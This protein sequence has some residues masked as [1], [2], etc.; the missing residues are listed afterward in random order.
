M[1]LCPDSIKS[2]VYGVALFVRIKRHQVPIKLINFCYLFLKCYMFLCHLACQ[3][4]LLRFHAHI[5]KTSIM[6]T[7]YETWLLNVYLK[8][9][10]DLSGER[11]LRT[12]EAIR[13][14]YCALCFP[15][16]LIYLCHKDQ[17]GIRTSSILMCCSKFDM[18]S[19]SKTCND[20][21]DIV[22]TGSCNM[23]SLD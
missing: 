7:D 2:M 23:M 15:V 12:R 3:I 19:S 5:L 9:T 20:D 14:L 11:Q 1:E 16:W 6:M 21:V 18:M 4:S 10:I 22:S 17:Q 8:V 13:F